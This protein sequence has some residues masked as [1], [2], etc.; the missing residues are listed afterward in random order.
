MPHVSFDTVDS[1]KQKPA[2]SSGEGATLV[3][4]EVGIPNVINFL[5]K[6]FFFV[7]HSTKIYN[8]GNFNTFS[9]AYCSKKFHNIELY[10]GIVSL[11]S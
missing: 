3:L 1:T 6:C 9:E 5:L 4:S 10:V 8:K 7:K 11:A 2:P